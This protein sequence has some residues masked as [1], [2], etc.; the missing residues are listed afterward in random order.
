MYN[1]IRIKCKGS[2]T[3]S[4]VSVIV[5]VY[6][7][8]NYLS[9][10]LDSL[11]NQTFKDFEVIIV[12]DGSTD[13]SQ[14]IIDKYT[15]KC[16]NF[17]GY[18]KENGGLSDARNYGIKKATGDYIALVDSDDYVDKSFLEKMHGKAINDNLDIVVCDAVNVYEDGK[19]E[20]IKS[21][22]HYTNSDIKNYLVA[23]PTGCIRLYKRNLLL[24]KG[25]KKGILYEDLEL[26]PSLV[27]QTKKIGFVEDGLYY[28]LQRSGSIMKQKT[29][30]EKLLDIFKV[31]DVNYKKLYKKYPLETEYIYITN[32]LRTATLRFLDYKNTKKYLKQINS[33]T[34]ERFPNWQNN[35]YLKKSSKK[36]QIICG[37]AYKKH[38][39]LL[40]LIKKIANK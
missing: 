15:K 28:Y 24:K 23:P 29:F 7:T 26:I 17:K 1:G 4:K 11:I 30:N 39:T 10:C 9:K 36:M 22:H 27:L 40:R 5:P 3:V 34:K 6:N 20:I 12:N 32:L 37:L 38:Y 18:I 25:F 19:E 33:I 21:N 8:E 13:N 2:E 16:S 14:E 31:L 35:M